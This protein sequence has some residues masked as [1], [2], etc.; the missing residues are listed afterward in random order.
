MDCKPGTAAGL[1]PLPGLVG[2]HIH[3]SHDTREV[4]SPR[5]AVKILCGAGIATASMLTSCDQSAAKAIPHQ[6]RQIALK[7]ALI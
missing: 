1:M 6:A 3:Y 5:R 7:R 4:L 2:R